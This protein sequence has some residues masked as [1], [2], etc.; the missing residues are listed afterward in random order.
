MIDKGKTRPEGTLRVHKGNCDEKTNMVNGILGPSTGGLTDT[1]NT[2]TAK[3]DTAKTD[4]AKTDP[5]KTATAE[6]V[7]CEKDKTDELAK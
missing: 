6:D 7:N 1:A 2:D 3:T 4:T 5:A